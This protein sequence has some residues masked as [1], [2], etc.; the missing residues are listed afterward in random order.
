LGL[1]CAAPAE[2]KWLSRDESR[3]AV[4]YCFFCQ[5]KYGKPCLD[6]AAAIEAADPRLDH[7]VVKATLK[8]EGIR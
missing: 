8:V 3:Q 7:R 6:D 5:S 2:A 4:L 1:T